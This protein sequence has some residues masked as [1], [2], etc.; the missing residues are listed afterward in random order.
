MLLPSA[1][2][3][4]CGCIR[5]ST[6]RTVW[7]SLTLLLCMPDSQGFYSSSTNIDKQCPHIASEAARTCWMHPQDRLAPE[8]RW[9][10]MNMFARTIIRLPPIGEKI[11]KE[12]NAKPL[13]SCFG[14]RFWSLCAS[15]RAVVFW[16]DAFHRVP[17]NQKPIIAWRLGW[18]LLS[19]QLPRYC[20]GD[21]CQD[22]GHHHSKKHSKCRKQTRI[23]NG[24]PCT[25]TIGFGMSTLVSRWPSQKHPQANTSKNTCTSCDLHTTCQGVW[26]SIDVVNLKEALERDDARG[27]Q[28]DHALH[29]QSGIVPS[30]SLRHWTSLDQCSGN[31][32]RQ[33]ISKH[34]PTLVQ[35]V[36]R[37]K[38]MKLSE[39]AWWQTMA[40][41]VITPRQTHL[42][43]AVHA[44]RPRPLAQSSIAVPPVLVMWM[45]L[46][47]SVCWALIGFC[48]VLLLYNYISVEIIECA[49]DKGVLVA[50][51]PKSCHQ[52]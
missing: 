10:M 30:A 18:S 44:R 36:T 14:V 49:A 52:N 27:C 1:G 11:Q 25:D 28:V 40:N 29:T 39:I 16:D 47:S 17:H 12:R 31:I 51:M 13:K 50:T 45:N 19:Q 4:K 41:R 35:H 5:P 22:K 21:L 42:P 48:N 9:T 23:W 20:F 3:Q 6:F 38:C 33:P 43:F 32:R 34:F 2:G 46:S 8:N 26:P 24:E 37:T 15:E 7:H